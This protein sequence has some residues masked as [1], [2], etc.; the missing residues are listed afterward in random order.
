VEG[1]QDPQDCVPDVV[2]HGYDEDRVQGQ[3][4]DEQNQREHLLKGGR[5]AVGVCGLVGAG[6]L[7][8]RREGLL[9][10]VVFAH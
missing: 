3:L 9:A 10:G 5:L 4:G 7:L 6:P 2:E 1:E 8:A